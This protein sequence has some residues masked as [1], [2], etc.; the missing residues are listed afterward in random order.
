MNWQLILGIGFWWVLDL[1]LIGY[2]IY[3]IARVWRFLVSYLDLGR[4]SKYDK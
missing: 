4:V 3:L 2:G 1:A